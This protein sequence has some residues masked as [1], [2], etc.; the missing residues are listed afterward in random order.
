MSKKAL[1]LLL[2]L[3]TLTLP[4]QGLPANSPKPDEGPSHMIWSAHVPF[5]GSSGS[6]HNLGYFEQIAAYG[7]NTVIL[8]VPWGEVEI[9]PDSFNFSILD[10]YVRYARDAGLNVIFGLL[11]AG[12]CSGGDPNPEPQFLLRNGELEVS[13]Q[14]KP[15]S[16]P[17]LS[18][19]N[20]TDRT[21]FMDFVKAII[22]RY[23]SY[24]NVR[25][26]L[27]NYGWLDD[28]W[29]PAV[30]GFPMGYS[31]SDIAEYVK[32]YLP[33]TYHNITALNRAWGTDYASFS[34]IRSAGPDYQDFRIWSINV[35]YSQI[36]DMVRNMTRKGL[37][38][39]WGGS[40]EDANAI[41]FPYLYFSLAK[42]YN[43]TII[44]DDA[45]QVENAELFSQLARKYDVG[46]MMEWTPSYGISNKAYYAYYLSHLAMAYPYLKGADYFAFIRAAGAW[47]T[48]SL[49]SMAI[50]I[51]S[52]F[53]GTYMNN[54]QSV[55]PIFA[56]VY[57]IRDGTSSYAVVNDWPSNLGTTTGSVNLTA[58]G[59]SPALNYSAL[60]FN[61][62]KL[63]PSSSLSLDFHG[64]SGTVFLGIFPTHLNSSIK[65]RYL[66]STYNA[67]LNC[68]VVRLAGFSSAPGE[69]LAIFSSKAPS[70]GL[71]SSELGVGNEKVQEGNFTL[72]FD[73]PVLVNGSY[74]LSAY[75]FNGKTIVAA[76]SMPV[77]IGKPTFATVPSLWE[78]IA[79]FA[80]LV[81]L[82]LVLYLRRGGSST[83]SVAVTEGDVTHSIFDMGLNGKQA[84][85]LLNYLKENVFFA[86]EGR[87][88]VN[89]RVIEGPIIDY[90]S[91]RMKVKLRFPPYELQNEQEL[92]LGM[93]MKG[94]LFHPAV[95]I[96][97]LSG[98][99]S[100]SHAYAKLVVKK[101]YEIIDRWLSGKT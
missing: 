95:E 85:D 37:F 73:M 83:R 15:D 99:P 48:F 97:R 68:S 59:Y 52:M 69:L 34:D 40:P 4:V 84:T 81:I 91:L 7:Y 9:G 30:D 2:M 33:A 45:D 58:L 13:P 66:G 12:F 55:L 27:I 43:V 98:D 94:D 62:G 32:F 3:I 39:Y 101:L 80:F 18:W 72:T 70:Q 63:M 88:P 22:S 78:P 87:R 28:D 42:R 47:P 64:D 76:Y 46:L 29:G 23:N 92:T 21:Y 53:N 1:I 61:N 26:Y 77:S 10:S 11:Y 71:I 16:P 86:G 31:A 25:G 49:N 51:Y 36:Y 20:S 6:P 5:L 24:P 57:V 14:G 44:L 65:L 75:L 100:R 38:L 35:T 19:W 41:Q 8:C 89:V 50:R 90:S 54:S 17:Y 96:R 56:N 60:D 93:E 67:T 74:D 79:V 82:A